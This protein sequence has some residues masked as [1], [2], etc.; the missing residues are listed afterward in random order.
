[1]PE[2]ALDPDLVLVIF[3]PPLLYSGAFFANLRDLTADLRSITL[4]SVGL[5]LATVVVVAVVAHELIPGFGWPEA[6]VLGAIV[7]PTDPVAATAIAAGSASRG[8]SCRSSRAS[9]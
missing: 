3:L 5:V 7:G 2:V 9:R 8:G 4:L 1:M 6:F